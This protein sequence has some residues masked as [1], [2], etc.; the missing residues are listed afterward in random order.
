VWYCNHYIS[1]KMANIPCE[2]LRTGEPECHGTYVDTVGSTNYLI[3]QIVFAVIAVFVTLFNLHRLRVVILQS[4][5]R[6][7]SKHL[8]SSPIFSP[9]FLYQRTIPILCVCVCVFFCITC[10]FGLT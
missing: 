4:G 10:H 1:R 9:L 7:K 2:Y 3:S 8:H 5:W 6:A